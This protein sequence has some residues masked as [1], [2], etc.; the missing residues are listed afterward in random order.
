MFKNMKL[1]AKM[2][3]MGAGIVLGVPGFIVYS[4]NT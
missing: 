3:F 1:S 2:F 4:V